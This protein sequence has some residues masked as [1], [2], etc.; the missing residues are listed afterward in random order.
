MGFSG[1][2]QK[3]VSRRLSMIVK[4]V[5]ITSSDS[6]G[7]ELKVKLKK[8]SSLEKLGTRD[9]GDIFKKFK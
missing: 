6:D 2:M 4:R 9:I 1:K 7:E 5:E 3:K 8:R